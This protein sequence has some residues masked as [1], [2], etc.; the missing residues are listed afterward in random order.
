MRR[1]RLDRESIEVLAGDPELL[2]IAEAVRSTQSTARPP[3]GRPR[4]LAAATAATAVALI[5]LAAAYVFGHTNDDGLLPRA[6]ASAGPTDSVLRA[7]FAIGAPAATVRIVIEPAAG[8]SS[9]TLTRPGK[10]PEQARLE[11]DESR[12][13]VTGPLPQ[14]VPAALVAF[15]ASYRAALVA[16]LAHGTRAPDGSTLRWLEVT[17]TRAASYE[18]AVDPYTGAPRIVRAAGVTYRLLSYADSADARPHG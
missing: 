1:R 8:S 2:A 14:G 13:V 5:L 18:V 7:A 4:F 12:L 6:R 3:S 9:V 17:P 16:G 10:P 15:A 11:V